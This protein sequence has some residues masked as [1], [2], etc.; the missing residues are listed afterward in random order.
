MANW[1]GDTPGPP[2]AYKERTVPTSST[3]AAFL[4]PLA[5][6]H[7]PPTSTRNEHAQEYYDRATYLLN[8]TLCPELIQTRKAGGGGSVSYLEGWRAINLAND[9]FGYNGWYTDIK[10]LE[11]DFIDYN[12]ETQRYNMGVTAIVRVR[13]QDGASHEDVGYGKL[14]NTKYK[15]EGLDKCKKEAVTDA[16]KRALRHFGKLLGNCLYDKDLINQMKNMKA[17]K[18]KLDFSAIYK[19]DDD[20]VPVGTEDAPWYRPKPAPSEV[21]PV[22]RPNPAAVTAAGAGRPAP[23]KPLPLPNHAQNLNRAKTVGSAPLPTPAKP[24]LPPS[25]NRAMGPPP[26]RAAT[27][28]GTSAPNP[29]DRSGAQTTAAFEDELATMD[30][31]VAPTA[32]GAHGGEGVTSFDGS[33]GETS[34]M[35][36][37][38]G[39]SFEGDSG[40]AE[41]EDLAALSKPHPHRAGPTANPPHHPPQQQQQQDA[42]ARAAAAAHN[43]AAAMARLAEKKQRE[44]AAAAAAAGTGQQGQQAQ[45]A[46]QGQHRRTS[47]TGAPQPLPAAAPVAGTGGSTSAAALLRS[48]TVGGPVHAAAGAGAAQL[49][50]ARPPGLRPAQAPSRQNSAGAGGPVGGGQHHPQ[51]L[52]PNQPQPHPQ[53]RT[54]GTLPTLNVGA[55][56][57][58]RGQTLPSGGNGHHGGAVPAARGE[59]GLSAS[60]PRAM[61]VGANGVEVGGAAAGGFVSARG[62]K[63]GSPG[64]GH[65]ASPSSHRSATLNGRTPSNPR[66]S[67]GPASSAS[68][69]GRRPFSELEVDQETG[70][71]KRARV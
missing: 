59:A 27:I 47:S 31:D 28:G 9:I 29:L 23:G 39:R 57:A 16:L 52:H 65:D 44:A 49:G 15:G 35:S 45:Q 54:A 50:S 53:P 64:D 20:N 33:E 34:M 43:K 19:P 21:K 13:L 63:R 41:A 6:G 46:Q 22:V 40:F 10:Y 11:A 48:S 4:N 58:A 32:G 7:Q 5:P 3:D 56:L 26:H 51:P 66:L 24:V 12:P 38:G 18:P 37:A 71:V 14:E 55:Q 68:S 25:A 62:V 8:K 36:A 17:P 2:T 61:S 1:M 60:P 70:G 67:G 42:Q 69:A 30:L